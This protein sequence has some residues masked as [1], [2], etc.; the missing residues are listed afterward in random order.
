MQAILL[1]LLEGM[2]ASIYLDEGY[3]Q[4]GGDSPF[5]HSQDS[6]VT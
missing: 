4:Y 5:N 3:L 1:N 6:W 2:G